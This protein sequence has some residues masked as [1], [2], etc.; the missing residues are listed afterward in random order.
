LMWR[1]GYVVD[2]ANEST[3]ATSTVKSLTEVIRRVLPMDVKRITKDVEISDCAEKYHGFVSRIVGCILEARK[4][5][6]LAEVYVSIIIKLILSR[7]KHSEVVYLRQL[8]DIR[9]LEREH[10]EYKSSLSSIVRYVK[11]YYK[12]RTAKE[13]LRL[14]LAIVHQ[15]SIPCRKRLELDVLA[16]NHMDRVYKSLYAIIGVM[17]TFMALAYII[18]LMGLAGLITGLAITAIAIVA[19][20]G[21]EAAR[22][23]FKALNFK[24]ESKW[25]ECSFSPGA[26]EDF[27]YKRFTYTGMPIRD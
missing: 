8:S 2:T 9:S 24:W 26:L 4:N 11:T 12:R 3:S 23:Y 5:P 18:S 7:L 16:E 15:L 14:V 20:L 1:S 6:H 13:A 27:I 25:A 19:I 22:A 10:V 17:A 21:E